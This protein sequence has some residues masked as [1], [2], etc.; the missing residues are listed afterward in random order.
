MEAR[1]SLVSLLVCA[2]LCGCR[3]T[4][5]PTQ[6]GLFGW[7]EQKAE[8]RQVAREEILSREEQAARRQQESETGLR[9]EMRL[10]AEDLEE[11]QKEISQLLA[12]AEALE[13]EAPTQA[14][15]GRA[16][17]LRREIDAVRRNEALSAG[18]RWALL[19]RYSA[20]VDL[21]RAQVSGLD[22]PPIQRRASTGED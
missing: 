1:S 11:Q 3:T 8:E 20:E 22:R 15:A 4:G 17:R 19:R 10:N 18:E 2:A 16:R 21:M 12:N 9:R 6:G 5:D 13:R 14:T 7:S